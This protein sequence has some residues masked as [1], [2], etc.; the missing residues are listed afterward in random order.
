[1]FGDTGTASRSLPDVIGKNS[2]ADNHLPAPWKA[3]SL[4]QAQGATPLLNR[5]MQ[6]TSKTPYLDLSQ[7]EYNK[8][9]AQ[10]RQPLSQT[11]YLDRL[12][13]EYNR[14]VAERLQREKQAQWIKTIPKEMA[15]TESNST[16]PPSGK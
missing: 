4:Q 8:L 3:A 11:P 5:I 6:S 2:V 13:E 10:R 1:M 14:L 16:R 9:V 15:L 7:G 12:T